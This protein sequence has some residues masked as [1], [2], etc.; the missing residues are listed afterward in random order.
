V[1]NGSA[2]RMVGAAGLEPATLYFGSCGTIGGMDILAG[3]AGLKTAS[4]FIEGFRK[5]LAKKE[6]NPDEVLGR[7][8]ELQG[9]ISDGRSALIDAQEEVLKLK[10]QVSS[11]NKDANV[12]PDGGVNWEKR[13]DDKYDGSLCPA[14]WGLSHKRVP[15]VKYEHSTHPD[16]VRYECLHHKPV[17]V[18]LRVPNSVLQ[19]YG[20]PI[21]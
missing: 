6:V 15:M 17:V 19:N 20:V 9:L 7:I 2:G 5:A 1:V 12:F 21:N 4:D 11:L 3:L 16:Y 14:C 13:S 10:A 18:T 8:I